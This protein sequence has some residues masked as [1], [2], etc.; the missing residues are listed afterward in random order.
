MLRL[1]VSFAG[2]AMWRSRMRSAMG[3]RAFGKCPVLR[4]SQESLRGAP[5]RFPI[6][7]P[8]TLRMKGLANPVSVV[9]LRWRP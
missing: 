7:E 6:S 3:C 9:S 8:Q 4:V 5:V 2:V 1:G